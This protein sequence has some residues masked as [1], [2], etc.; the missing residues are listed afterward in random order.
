MIFIH[1]LFIFSFKC[2]LTFHVDV[3][4]NYTCEVILNGEQKMIKMIKFSIYRHGYLQI[5]FTKTY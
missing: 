1:I 3:Q 4:Y 2:L 5:N